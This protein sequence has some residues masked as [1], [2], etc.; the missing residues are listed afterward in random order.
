M[1]LCRKEGHCYSELMQDNQIIIDNRPYDILFTFRSPDQKLFLLL[2]EEEQVFAVRYE[3]NE[4]GEP[5]LFPVSDRQ[6]ERI[7][8]AYNQA[9]Q[10]TFYIRD[11][12]YHRQTETAGFILA[13]SENDPLIYVPF[14]PDNREP[15]HL[16]EAGLQFVQ[17]SLQAQLNLDRQILLEAQ[18]GIDDPERIVGEALCEQDGVSVYLNFRRNPAGELVFVENGKPVV[19][20]DRQQQLRQKFLD[21]EQSEYKE[22]AAVQVRNA[23]VPEPDGSPQGE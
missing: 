8:S 17:D 12:P 5:E 7:I 6:I 23:P 18:P 1:E 2:Q 14:S 22:A 13:S 20:K 10:D 15:V 9:V 3:E 21:W 19:R 16:D 4:S 11:V